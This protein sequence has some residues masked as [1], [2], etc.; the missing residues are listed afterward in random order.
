MDPAAAAGLRTLLTGVPLP[1]ERTA[2]LEYAV[3]QR[4]EP[5]LL[6]ALQSLPEREFASLE[7]VVDELLHVQPRTVEEIPQPRAESGGPP[8]GDDYTNPGPQSGQVRDLDTV[9]Q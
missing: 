7:E 9:E 1:A 8:G 4:A 6:E 5:P 2:L 3:R